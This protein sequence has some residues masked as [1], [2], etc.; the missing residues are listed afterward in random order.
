MKS[1]EELNRLREEALKKV[2]L[3]QEATQYRILVGMA[4]CGI[5]A[6]ARPVMRALMEAVAK[7]NLPV[8]LQQTGC[9]GMCRYEPIV[10]VIDQDGEKTSYLHVTPEIALL[11]LEKHVKQGQI[12]SQYTKAAIME[13]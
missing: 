3:R 11:I 2:N 1:L 5:A 6:G 9:I 12:L 10:E 13:E 8:T 4:T 7:E